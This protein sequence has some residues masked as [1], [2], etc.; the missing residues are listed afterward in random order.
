MTTWLWEDVAS[1]NIL[2]NT[3]LISSVFNLVT[4]TFLWIK[5]LLNLLS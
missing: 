5:M 1:K 4:E 3:R 2:E